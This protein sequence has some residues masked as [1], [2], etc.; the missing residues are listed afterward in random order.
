MAVDSATKDLGFE[1]DMGEPSGLFVDETKASL[2]VKNMGKKSWGKRNLVREGDKVV[3]A[4]H[5]QTTKL[6]YNELQGF[7]DKR[8]LTMV[9][10]RKINFNTD[11]WNA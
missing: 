11:T 8:P 4:N 7:L 3:V 6:K 5:F 1:V 9:V 10:E 2:L